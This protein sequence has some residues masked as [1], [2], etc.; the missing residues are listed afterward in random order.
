MRSK[1]ESVFSARVP[2]SERTPS[3][4]W[5]SGVKQTPAAAATILLQDINNRDWIEYVQI[6]YGEDSEEDL[7]ETKLSK[8]MLRLLLR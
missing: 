5:C 4:V 6:K 2:S 1:G 8:R 3:P 7:A